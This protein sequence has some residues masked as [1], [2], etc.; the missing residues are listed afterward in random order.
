M[1]KLTLLQLKQFSGFENID[2][3]IALYII[4]SLFQFSVI[5]FNFFHLNNSK[6]S[7]EYRYN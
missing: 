6:Q 4:E 7:G 3:K 2:D 1:K 5:A